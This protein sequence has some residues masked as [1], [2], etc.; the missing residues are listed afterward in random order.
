[1]RVH[2]RARTFSFFLFFVHTRMHETGATS[3][4]SG[5]YPPSFSLIGSM[6]LCTKR[7]RTVSCTPFSYTV[8]VHRSRTPFSCVV[9]AVIF[10]RSVACEERRESPFRPIAD[11]RES[12]S[13]C[14]EQSNSH[15]R[16]WARQWAEQ[17]RGGG[18]RRKNR[19]T[20]I[21]SRQM[22]PASLSASRSIDRG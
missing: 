20:V 3:A 12:I 16:G 4:I 10:Q 18:E 22:R 9:T 13:A 17:G 5:R 6:A 21:G 14:D 1:M 7:S 15:A 11:S 8:L 19:V 2:A